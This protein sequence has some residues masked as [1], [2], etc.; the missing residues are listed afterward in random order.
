[1]ET[2]ATKFTYYEKGSTTLRGSFLVSDPEKICKYTPPPLPP[3][4]DE[5]IP[6]DSVTLPPIF[7]QKPTPTITPTETFTY[8]PTPT[9]TPTSTPTSSPTPTFT[10]TTTPT[11]PPTLTPT[12]TPTLIFT[13]YYYT[14][15]GGCGYCCEQAPDPSSGQTRS[16][17]TGYT[18]WIQP[19]TFT[20][21][22]RTYYVY[23]P[24][25]NDISLYEADNFTDNCC[26]NTYL[27]SKSPSSQDVC[28][29]IKYDELQTWNCRAGSN[30]FDWNFLDEGCGDRLT[31]LGESGCKGTGGPW[32]HGEKYFLDWQ[33]CK[34]QS[35]PA[36]GT[37]KNYDTLGNPCCTLNYGLQ[38][39][40]DTGAYYSMGWNMLTGRN[41]GVDCLCGWD[42]PT[43]H[44]DTVYRSGCKNGL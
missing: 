27:R 15:V 43:N 12:P 24:G 39:F 3:D 25:P 35:F 2:R 23:G 20:N 44:G 16:G 1:M 4:D 28:D 40:G 26:A 7:P 18:A 5:F 38:S 32:P 22:Y 8:S 6:D 9:V 11:R 33:I 13:E 31:R 19:N 21:W 30:R 14:D 37:C 36:C 17:L 29:N 42:E 41:A 10:Y 34:G